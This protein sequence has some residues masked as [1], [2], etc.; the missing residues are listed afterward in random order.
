MYARTLVPASR[1]SASR[2]AR[3]PK[4]VPMRRLNRST[5]LLLLAPLAAV[6]AGSTP[7]AAAPVTAASDALD[8]ACV[9]LRVFDGSNAV[10]YVVRDGDGYKFSGTASAATPVRLE[11]T[12]LNRY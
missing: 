12:R 9:A 4:G 7:A 11:A 2:R 5:A 6:A 10:G 1:V 3:L 8:G